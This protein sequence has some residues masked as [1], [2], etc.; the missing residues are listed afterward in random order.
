MK[1]SKIVWVL[2]LSF[3]FSVFCV[4]A[5]GPSEWVV[6]G[7][8]F[9]GNE[10]SAG[11]AVQLKGLDHSAITDKEGVFTL[12]GTATGK[13][14]LQ[15]HC[16]GCA[17]WDSL[18]TVEPGSRIMLTISLQSELREISQVQIFGSKSEAMR[19]LPGAA[20]LIT[21]LQI[22]QIQPVSANEV[23]RKAPG[24]H[25]VDEEGLGLR[26]NIGIRGLDPDRSRYVLVLEDGVPVSLSPY[27]EPE[28][29]Y[30]PSIDRMQQVEVLKGSSSIQYGPRT[31][32]GVVNYRT[33]DP[34]VKPE[35]KVQLTGGANGYLSA[36]V[37]YGTTVGNTGIQVN[38]LRKQT[39]DFGM[40]RLRLNDISAKFRWMISSKE[41]IG[42]KLGVYDE[43]SNANYIGMTQP[44]YLSGQYDVARLAPEDQFHIRRYSASFT[45]NYIVSERFR[46]EMLGF[47]Y[48]TQRNWCRQD[49]AYNSID[50]AGNLLPKPSDYSGV[51][52]GDES[53]SGGAIYMRNSTG[54]RNRT[55]DVAGSEVRAR[56]AF[57]LGAISNELLSGIRFMAEKAHEVRVNGAF[58]GDLSGEISDEE[59]RP[60]SG[61]SAFVSDKISLGPQLE[62]T[63]GIR[64]EFMQFNREIIRG[65]YKINNVT[66]ARDTSIE[67]SG[68]LMQVIPGIGFTYLPVKQ[69][70][71]FGG[72]H[73]GFA[74]PRI[75]DAITSD[76]T[77]QELSAEL[78]WNYELGIRSVPLKGVKLELTA[79]LL[80]FENQVIPVSESSGGTGTGLMNGGGT[81][82]K[83]LEGTLAFNSAEIRKTKWSAEVLVNAT[84]TLASFNGDRFMGSA[85]NKV[86]INGNVLP[87]VPEWS[88]N[89]LLSVLS[90]YHL[91]FN[92]NL[93]YTGEQY[94]DVL[95]TVNPT[96]NGLAGIIPSFYTLD[97]GLG[98]DWVKANASINCS[99]KNLTDE[100]YIYT[101]RPQGIRVGLERMIFIG[102]SKRF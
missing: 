89:M 77:D 10:T 61:Y 49:F 4:N 33:I 51:T 63:P 66:T 25:A 64:A 56:Y 95:N 40:L 79:F 22:K 70:T 86:N 8:V 15:L 35:G 69:L 73:R 58:A 28:M 26:P 92:C 102:V 21:P 30:S 67:N 71:I 99:V 42:F 53:I 98:F 38:Y 101:R 50:T 94:T 20:T 83:G 44:M 55:F 57:T 93:Q 43:L 54:N 46:V 96:A 81:E 5:Q 68:S 24:V 90:P 6:Q 100:R 19:N 14:H 12:K 62:F 65:K 48:T 9:T 78:S 74:P 52:W 17:D 47:A 97:A 16:I 36:L 1:V 76:G 2:L 41:V 84:Y 31:I 3:L 23:L 59:Y 91:R 18:I 60:V 27:G 39:D 29:Y 72:V 13:F 82:S 37:G 32:A 45:Y 80:D 7:K 11:V 34:P 87:Y 85:E 88:G 75:K